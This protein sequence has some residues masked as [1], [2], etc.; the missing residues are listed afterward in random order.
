MNQE[1]FKM[2]KSAPTTIRFNPDTKKRLD[3]LSKDLDVP[4]SMLVR[5]AT[6]NYLSSLPEQTSLKDALL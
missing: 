6:E 4:I 2:K 1:S 3:E 5:K